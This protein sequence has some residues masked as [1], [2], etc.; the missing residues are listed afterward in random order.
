MLQG[1]RNTRWPTAALGAALALVGII[2]LATAVHAA[3]SPRALVEQSADRV[4][5]ILNSGASE[6]VK[7]KRLQSVAYETIDF[8]TVSRLV[9]A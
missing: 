9:L 3:D 4:L 5:A 1:K 6:D 8:D 2:L 7:V